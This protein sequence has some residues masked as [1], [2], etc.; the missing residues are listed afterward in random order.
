MRRHRARKLETPRTLGPLA[1]QLA[2]QKKHARLVN[3]ASRIALRGS[4]R[5]H[6]SGPPPHRLGT[7]GSP[8]APERSGSMRARRGRHASS[9]VLPHSNPDLRYRST[10]SCSAQAPELRPHRP[11][12]ARHPSPALPPKLCSHR[13]SF[14]PGAGT[15]P[16]ELCPES[17][18]NLHRAPPRRQ[19][20]ARLSFK[21]PSASAGFSV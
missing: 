21:K 18:N 16:P 19:S 3:Q 13:S 11:S 10:A 4:E 20:I 9:A 8:H 15:H 6:V 14:I 5:L 1:K 17:R 2:T 12:S 7:D